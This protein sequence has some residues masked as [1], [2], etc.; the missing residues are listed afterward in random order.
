MDSSWGDG[1]VWWVGVFSNLQKLI[2]WIDAIEDEAISPCKIVGE[3]KD[4]LSG[5]FGGVT[6][7]HSITSSIPRVGLQSP[8]SKSSL[9]G[10]VALLAV[11]VDLVVKGL[12]DLVVVKVA[13]RWLLWSPWADRRFACSKGSTRFGGTRLHVV[14]SPSIWWPTSP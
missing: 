12:V 11:H 8:R 1:N 7:R 13:V 4:G 9:A 5:Q 14:G 2:R 10:L 3:D 6:I